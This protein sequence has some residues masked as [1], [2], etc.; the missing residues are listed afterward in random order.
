MRA[1][2]A[3]RGVLAAVVVVSV[4][5]LCGVLAASASATPRPPFPPQPSRGTLYV[6][7]GSTLPSRGETWWD[8]QWG[9]W[10]SGQW[11]RRPGSSCAT[12]AFT[13]I[14]AAVSAAAP[15]STIIVCPGVYDEGVLIGKQIVLDGEGGAVIDASSSPLGNGVQIVGPGGSGSTVE[16]FKIENAEFEG[17][18][19]GTAPV[20]P[21]TTDGT[22]VT[23][24]TPVSDVT[25]ANNTLV[26]NGTGFGSDAGQ[27][28]SSTPETPGDCG[29]TIHLVSVTNSVVEGNNV[30]DNVGGI[31][32]TD[33]FGPTSGNTVRNNQALDNT[34]DC[35]ITLAGHSPAAVSPVT[36]LPTGAAGVFDNLIANNVSDDN[37][38]AGQGAGILLGGGAPFAG[39]YDNT[40][41]GNVASGNGLAGITIHQHF[42]GDLNGNVLVG[43]I[44][45]NDN[46]DGDFDFA[47]AQATQTTGILVAAGLPPGLP[48]NLPP[49][50]SPPGITGT[51]IRG[52]VIFGVKVGIW[53]LGVDPATTTISGNLF[54]FGVTTPVSTN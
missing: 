18:L 16:G 46:L 29:E 13:T 39:V 34:D 12:A 53:T 33:E 22:A 43:N 24:G 51:I 41:V 17:I 30:A 36:G 3:R 2:F 42:V 5:G 27:C 48:A 32:L 19:V 10:Q 14:G 28:Y 9:A 8:G 25:I 47:A 37:G 7:N 45:S 44:L 50:P 54:G 49:P 23:S 38:V 21:T 1:W 15:G 40:I 4:G 11:Y 20:A 52:N 31:L 6:N 26:D 35:G